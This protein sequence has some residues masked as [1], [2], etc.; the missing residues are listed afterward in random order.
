MVNKT[1]ALSFFF[2]GQLVLMAVMLYSCVSR[3]HLFI[4]PL[5]RMWTQVNI[6]QNSLRFYK[7]NGCFQQFYIKC[8][9]ATINHIN[10]WI[11]FLF[12]SL[13]YRTI[14]RKNLLAQQLFFMMFFYVLS[15]R[16][17]I[18]LGSLSFHQRYTVLLLFLC[19]SQRSHNCMYFH[20]R[21]KIHV[22]LVTYARK[23]GSSIRQTY[24]LSVNSQLRLGS[25]FL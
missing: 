8:K 17:V 14:K 15:Q 10:N 2:E 1:G 22:S 13:S 3:E 11:L 23:I 20:I 6:P 12:F 7:E 9:C 5:A 4:L 19:K 18:K 21:C 24:N 25:T 16:K